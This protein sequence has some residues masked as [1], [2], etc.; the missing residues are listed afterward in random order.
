MSSACREFL[1]KGQKN[2]PVWGLVDEVR[3]EIVAD[4]KRCFGL[5]REALW[6]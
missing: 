1:D 3:D 4:A 2:V 6:K 5:L